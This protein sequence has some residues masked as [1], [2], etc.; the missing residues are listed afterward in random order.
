MTIFLCAV[1]YILLAYS[2]Y[3]RN[4]YLLIPYSF[5]SPPSSLSPLLTI[6]LFCYVQA[7]GGSSKS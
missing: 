3:N 6:S 4:L 2:L 7:Y 1:Q 5:L